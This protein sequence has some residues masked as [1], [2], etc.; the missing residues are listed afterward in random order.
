[1]SEPQLTAYAV[2]VPGTRFA[3]C[4]AICKALQV[5]CSQS[6]R[7]DNLAC[8]R[9]K[10][11]ALCLCAP[12]TRS[13]VAPL[14]DVVKS[15]LAHR[16]LSQASAMRAKRLP[17]DAAAAFPSPCASPAHSRNA[18]LH[19]VD[20]FLS[21]GAQ[22]SMSVLPTAPQKQPRHPGLGTAPRTLSAH[23]HYGS[24]GCFANFLL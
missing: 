15:L 5:N 22:A 24:S 4:F 9:G 14:P 11:P 19:D 13:L 6:R 2:T 20:P 10:C 3:G 21:P 18:R 17:R 1:M 8:C 12:L 7:P 23:I 16:G